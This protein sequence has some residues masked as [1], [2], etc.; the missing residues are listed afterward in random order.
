M[1]VSP[2]LSQLPTACIKGDMIIV[3]VSVEEYLVGMQDCKNH[4]CWIHNNNK[5]ETQEQD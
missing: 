3:Q 4:L 1:H 5:Q 2:T